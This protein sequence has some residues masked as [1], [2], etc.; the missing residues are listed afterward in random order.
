MNRKPQTAK[1]VS[2]TFEQKWGDDPFT[3][4]GH[5][6]IPNALIQYA[7]RLKL[8]PDECWLITCILFH[9]R[10]AA[11][12]FPGQETLTEMYGRSV[13]TVQRVIKSIRAKGLMEVQHKRSE[14]G[15]F[16]HIVYDFVPLRLALNECYYQDHP[17]QRPQYSQPVPSL[18]KSAIPQGCGTAGEKRGNSKSNISHTAR[19]R[20]GRNAVSHTAKVPLPMPQGCGTNQTLKKKIE[21]DSSEVFASLLSEEEGKEPTARPW[22]DLPEPERAPWLERAEAELKENFGG[23]LW[24]KTKEKARASIR[25]QRAAN[26]YLEANDGPPEP[27]AVVHTPGPTCRSVRPG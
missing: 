27:K 1:P 9:K 10:T 12:P 3:A 7:S 17:E 8:A 2:C 22:P 16:S 14:L 13:D 25:G 15:H 11:A 18:A 23:A 19:L 24:A 26:L 20:Y 21:I 5:T 4:L 6:Q